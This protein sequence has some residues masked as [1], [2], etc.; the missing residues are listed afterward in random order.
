M[1]ILTNPTSIYKL[2]KELL[3]S[4]ENAHKNTQSTGFARLDIYFGGI[5]QGDVVVIGAR[6]GMGKTQFAVNLITNVYD[7]DACLYFSLTQSIKDITSRFIACKTGIEAHKLHGEEVSSQAL[8]L[9]QTTHN[10]FEKVKLWISEVGN[11]N[12]DAILEAIKAQVIE[13]QIKVVVID[14][15]Q[16][17]MTSK[18]KAKMD[19][20]ISEVLQQLKQMAKALNITVIVL[21]NL[22]RAVEKRPLHVPKLSDLMKQSKAL[23]IVDKVWLLYRPAYYG[24]E[25][26]ENGSPAGQM[27]QLIIAKNNNG[28][29]GAVDFKLDKGF[30]KFEAIELGF[31]PIV[32]SAKQLMPN[33]FTIF[34]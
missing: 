11:H 21:S 24:I 27:A 34:I 20:Q 3:E 5:A 33:A 8:E 6:P 7:T 10:N 1:P 19:A 15:L 32:K 22:R 25:T 16:A 18:T 4:L 13:H 12:I 2:S 17:I 28:I 9:I 30:T 26:F 23:A 29:E 14:D 31:K